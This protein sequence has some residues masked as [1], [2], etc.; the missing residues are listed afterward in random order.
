MK[1]I[2]AQ[3]GYFD[4]LER[5]LEILFRYFSLKTLRDCYRK[6]IENE[7]EILQIIHEIHIGA[8]LSSVGKL[9]GMKVPNP[10]DPKKNYDFKIPFEDCDFNVEVKTRLDFP[11]EG[12][13]RSFAFRREMVDQKYFG[14]SNDGEPESN[15]IRAILEGAANQLPVLELNIIALGQ[16]FS[17]RAK[18]A[19]DAFRNAVFGDLVFEDCGRDNRGYKRIGNGLFMQDDFKQKISGV[20]WFQLKNDSSEFTPEY[21]LYLNPN[22]QDP[23][24]INIKEKLDQIFLSESSDATVDKESDKK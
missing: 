19:L 12:S 2:E 13:E 20:I 3:K 9:I 17:I 1:W 6:K 16:I 10:D 5:D 8:L 7:S 11:F 18:S 24:L 23:R 21:I 15:R 22:K 14:R 4:I